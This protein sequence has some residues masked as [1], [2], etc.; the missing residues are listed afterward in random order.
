MNPGPNK[1]PCGICDRPVAKNHRGLECDECGYWVHIKCGDVTS[2]DYE[3]LLLKEQFT[4]ICPRC[5]IPN[6]SD[7]FFDE[8]NLAD[9]NL[10]DSLSDLDTSMEAALEN[11]DQPRTSSPKSKNPEPQKTKPMTKS[12]LKKGKLKFMTINCDGLKGKQRQQYLASLIDSEQPD[13]IMGQE[14]KLD[15]S[16]TDS[17][18]F[19]DGYLVKRK[20]RNARG[21]GV[22]IAYRDNLVVN[23]VK[24]SGK[25]CE[26]VV[27]KVEV[28]KT[29]PIYIAC[30]YRQPNRETEPL[31]SLQSD[32]EKIFNRSAVPKINHVR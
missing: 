13:I 18:V 16:Y 10:F 3:L 26:L 7:S 25:K 23:E 4:W 15:N 9:A 20:D 1:Y 21:G 14:S 30:Y 12:K 31:Q 22:F 19:P 28:W 17:E 24:G 29:T 27:L 2:T 32:L 8:S 11:A 5:A 6:F